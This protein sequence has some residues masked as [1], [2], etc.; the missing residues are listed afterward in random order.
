V[1][2]R[3]AKVL[4]F[5]SA[6]HVARGD[7]CSMSNLEILVTPNILDIEACD[8]EREILYSRWRLYLVPFARLPEP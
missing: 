6:D 3:D 4:A 8:L 2:G 1:G 7:V 5:A